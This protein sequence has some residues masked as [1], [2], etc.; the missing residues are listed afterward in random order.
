M[1][2]SCIGHPADWLSPPEDPAPPEPVLWWHFSAPDGHEDY[3]SDKEFTLTL[4]HYLNHF[5]SFSVE[6]FDAE[7][8]Y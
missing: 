3:V 6:S 8:L 5:P 4:L 7:P 2:S 1:T